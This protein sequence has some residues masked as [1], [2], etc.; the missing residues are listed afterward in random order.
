MER[1]TSSGMPQISAA[2]AGW[3]TKL[4]LVKRVEVVVDGF[5]QYN[6]TPIKFY[7][8]MQPLSARDISLKPEGQRSW[9]WLQMHCFA[10][11]IELIPG[12]RIR[13]NGDNY[14]VMAQNDYSLN[15]YIEYHL[16]R[17]FQDGGSE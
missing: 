4:L 10:R 6:D 13:W 1:Q 14:K 12:D 17:E 16:V 5:V 11:S 2:F 3:T 7:G 15:G 9:T 8:T